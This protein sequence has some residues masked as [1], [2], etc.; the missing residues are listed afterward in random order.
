[1]VVIGAGLAGLC[2]ALACAEDGATV[3]VLEAGAVGGRTT[4]HSTAKL[5]ALH[6]D[7]YSRLRRGK[8]AEAAAVYASANAA[9]V[10]ALGDTIGRLGIDCALTAATTYTCAETSEGIARVEDEADAARAAGLPVELV[11]AAL[12]VP[13]AVA[14]ALADQAHLDPV[15][16]CRGLA[17]EIRRLGGT[18]AEG[19]RVLEIDE[20][21][22]GCTVAAEG[23]TIA[24]DAAVV[25]THLPVVDPAFLAARV[26]PERSYVVAGPSASLA[27][28]GMYLSVDRGWSVRP[29]AT[30]E[31]PVVLVGGAGHSMTDDVDGVRHLDDLEAAA[32]ATFGVGARYRWSAFDYTTTDGVPFI[33]RLAP[34]SHRRFVA[35][36]FGK[37]GI[38]HSMVA[39]TLISDLI[40]GR[41]NPHHALYDSTRIV[42]TVSRDLVSN[43]VDVAQRF[44][45]DRIR[46]RR[47]P[48]DALPDP[49]CGVVVHREGATV[50]I[51]RSADGRVHAV[52]AACTHLGCIVGFNDAD[53]TWDC[54]CHGS[55]FALDGTVLDGPATHPLRPIP[56]SN[57]GE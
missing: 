26:R 22:D 23:V 37:W 6:G 42:A 20:A 14:V 19:V 48:A 39:A 5:T 53:Q 3:A 52:D 54:P 17:A 38:S 4:G 16:L 7:V 45:G 11:T 21:D 43:T 35:T 50:A 36:G 10:R 2:T 47:R 8:G 28:A 57:D 33:G 34:R 49:G 40:A 9:A 25:T 44:V 27:P 56:L 24:C 13:A 51:A 18:V 55:R 32:S 31:G 30:P 15:S 12:E 29:A 1:V 41:D 46:A